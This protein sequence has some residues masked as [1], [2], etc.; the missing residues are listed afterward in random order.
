[1]LYT[2]PPPPNQNSAAIVN[3]RPLI[4][5]HLSLC[6]A[7]VIKFRIRL[8]HPSPPFWTLSPWDVVTMFF[9]LNLAPSNVLI[10]SVLWLL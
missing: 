10:G 5:V 2:A 4:I 6:E 1:M 7:M 9:L 8:F 3:M